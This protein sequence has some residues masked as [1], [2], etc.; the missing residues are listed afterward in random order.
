MMRK[1]QNIGVTLGKASRKAQ[2]FISELP[3]V[4]QRYIFL[5]VSHNPDLP[6]PL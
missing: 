1:V 3:D 4:R 6:V 2:A 5:T